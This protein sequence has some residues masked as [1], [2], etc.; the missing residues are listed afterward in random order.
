MIEKIVK[1]IFILII[2]VLLLVLLMSYF[3]PNVKSLNET[4]NK[5]LE[6]WHEIST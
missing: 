3:K 1:I 4:K 2:L 6:K 5:I